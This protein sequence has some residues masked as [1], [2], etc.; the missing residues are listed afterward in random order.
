VFSSTLSK[1]KGL[2]LLSL[3]ATLI[4]LITGLVLWDSI[5]THSIQSIRNHLDHWQPLLTAIRWTLI[6]GLALGWQLLCRLWIRARN[7]SHLE[8][9]QLITLRWRIVGW[10]VVIELTLGQGVFIKAMIMM[11]GQS[12]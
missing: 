12:A 4:A 5:Q 8:A 1:R 2:L 10:L 3:T 7:L 9:H 6:G 11:T